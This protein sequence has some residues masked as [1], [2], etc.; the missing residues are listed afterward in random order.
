MYLDVE[1]DK[2]L[3][4]KEHETYAVPASEGAHEFRNK[5]GDNHLI[6]PIGTV[7]LDEDGKRVMANEISYDTLSKTARFGKGADINRTYEIKALRTYF[8]D[9]IEDQSL[10]DDENFYGGRKFE[11][12]LRGRGR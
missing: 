7:D 9:N 3:I 1:V 10:R 6:L 8:P 2:N 11:N 12:K 4:D 5:D